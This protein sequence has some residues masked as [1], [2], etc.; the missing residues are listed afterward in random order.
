MFLT[1]SAGWNSATCHEISSFPVVF[2]ERGVLKNFSKLTGKHKKQSSGGV[3]SKDLLKNFAK[4]TETPTQL[5]SWEFCELFKITYFIEH[6]R[7]AC[8]EMPVRG[9]LF[10]RFRFLQNLMAWRPLIVLER[11]SS[12]GISLWILWSF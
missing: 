4:F 5:F 2:Y 3:L 12:T 8:S 9:S 1:V 10:S 7:T 6:L 11:D